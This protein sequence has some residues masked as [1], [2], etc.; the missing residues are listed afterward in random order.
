MCAG[1]KQFSISH[2]QD[3]VP[4]A[5]QAQVDLHAKDLMLPF[6]CFCSRR[7]VCTISP[8]FPFD[9]TQGFSYSSAFEFRKRR[10]KCRLTV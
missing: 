2:V 4:A 1:G 6:Q 5:F 3:H 8:T 7:G 10:C 9:E